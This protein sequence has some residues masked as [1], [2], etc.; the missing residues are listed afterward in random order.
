MINSLPAITLPQF[1]A[2]K[3]RHHTADPLLA[4]DSVAGIVEGNVVVEV[5][6]VVG[7]CHGGLLGLEGGGFGGWHFEFGSIR[8]YAERIV[9]CE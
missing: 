5:D 2:H 7:G 4:D 3:T 8:C 1:L 6:T 9:D